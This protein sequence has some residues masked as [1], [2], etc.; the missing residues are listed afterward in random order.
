MESEENPAGGGS[1][2]P[3]GDAKGWA[4]DT[5]R[6]GQSLIIF[7]AVLLVIHLMLTITSISVPAESSWMIFNIWEV[8]RFVTVTVVCC[9]LIG[10]GWLLCRGKDCSFLRNQSEAVPG[11][12]HALPDVRKPE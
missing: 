10:L 11:E 12:E 3:I 6:L 4:I 1:G 7:G 5:G 9:V 8:N 2:L